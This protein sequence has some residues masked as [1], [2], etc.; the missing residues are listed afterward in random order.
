MYRRYNPDNKITLIPD[1]AVPHYF[2][3]EIET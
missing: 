2:I 1:E 3:P